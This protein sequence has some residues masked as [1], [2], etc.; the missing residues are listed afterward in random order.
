MSHVAV[1]S[2]LF[3]LLLG[4]SIDAGPLNLTKAVNTIDGEV[5]VKADT[6]FVSKL[7]GVKSQ[8]HWRV[9]TT[10]YVNPN[11]AQA[12]DANLGTLSS[13][14]KTLG[15]ALMRVRPG[16]R[17]LLEPGYY[18]ET[19][20][21]GAA[22]SGTA[23]EPVII[24]SRVK[25]K[26]IFTGSDVWTGWV[27]DG[28][29]DTYSHEWT[30]HWGA[31]LMGDNIKPIG[32]RAEM[33]FV[34]GE[35]YRQV[36][37]KGQLEGKT[38]CVS[39]T[40]HKLWVRLPKGRDPEHAH[41]E[42]SVRPAAIQM[43][44]VWGPLSDHKDYPSYVVLRGLRAEHYNMEPAV[45]AHGYHLLV[46][47]CA[48]DWNNANGLRMRGIDLVIRRCTMSHNGY[49]G[50]IVPPMTQKPGVSDVLI[51]DTE[52]SNCNWRGDMGGL[53]G[54]DVAGTKIMTSDNILLQRFS[55]N[56]NLAPG[57]W[58]DNNNRNIIFDDCRFFRNDGP[59]IMVEID[60]GPIAIRDT[61][62]AYNGSGV[63][64]C[65]S[66]FV[67]I[68]RSTL[69]DN[70]SSQ[71]GEWSPARDREGFLDYDLTLRDCV[72]AASSN[73]FALWQRPDYYQLLDTVHSDRNLWYRP[74]GEGWYAG[75]ASLSLTKWM[76]RTKGDY[77]SVFTDP[78][79]RSPKSSDFRPESGS[80][81][82]SRSSWGT[83]AVVDIQ[84]RRAL[85]LV[86]TNPPWDHTFIY[87][88]VPSRH[89]IHYTT[90][91]STPIE[92]SLVYSGPFAADASMTIKAKAFGEHPQFDPVSSAEIIGG[93]PSLPDVGLQDLKPTR[94]VVG[95][96]DASQKDRSIMGSPIQMAGIGFT[97]GMGTHASSEL[98]YDLKL[99]F[100]RFV[101]VVGVDD[102]VVGQ[103]KVNPSLQFWVYADDQL[104]AKTDAVT[105]GELKFL[106]VKI[107]DGHK[108][109][110]L[111][112]T[113]A[114]AG[115]DWCHADWA[116]AG[117]IK[118]SN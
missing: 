59:G 54:D 27:L 8:A 7:W 61:I 116:S 18:P 53:R 20:T 84:P 46:E 101:A 92:S 11:S 117:F 104:L 82:L 25:G 70:H 19:V 39:E 102:E 91:G 108:Q 114:R 85:S 43:G 79:F 22:Q 80:P 32:R 4:G 31:K 96:G 67:T 81:L 78:M 64:I 17:I 112:V 52:T 24:E 66:S 36:E 37:S 90:D 89:Q 44:S 107:P 6:S 34:D 95:Y 9:T 41:I 111:K 33:V 69:Y 99:D 60:P 1:V 29:N 13:P 47:D 83:R 113:S 109:I 38:Y 26:A 115:T 40:E 35:W 65:N 98:N 94:D 77:H 3:V 110:I 28:S 10:L 12:S 21:I 42:V 103:T 74:D 56:D 14:F 30:Y 50:L 72:I 118:K 75:N 87:M 62:S 63:S 93:A 68:E 88:S 97:H 86:A 57:I 45:S 55:A 5:A 23:T 71:I 2:A 76:L 16:T 49:A 48:F 105:V 51:A 15:A 100:K 106:D 73:A 58:F